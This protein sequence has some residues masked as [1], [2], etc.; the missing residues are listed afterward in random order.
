[1]FRNLSFGEGSGP[2]FLSRV[3]CTSSDLELLDC[4]SDPIGIHT[5]SHSEDVGIQ[6]IG[7]LKACGFV[8]ITSVSLLISDYDECVDDN[9]G[10]EQLCI[11]LIPGHMC[12]CYGGYNLGDDGQSCNGTSCIMLSSAS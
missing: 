11:N 12:D 2:I 9:G 10:C 6:C 8:L 3:T 4:D 7:M 5:C 1:M